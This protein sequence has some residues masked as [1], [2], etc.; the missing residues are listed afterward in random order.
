[1]GSACFHEPRQSRA[2]PLHVDF[3]L[4]E[5]HIPRAVCHLFNKLTTGLCYSSIININIS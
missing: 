1:M 3:R 5:K 2:P 4:P